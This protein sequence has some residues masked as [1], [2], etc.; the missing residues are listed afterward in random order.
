MPL[1]ANQHC[2][3]KICKFLQGSKQKCA[4]SYL[5]KAQGPDVGDWM[6]NSTGQLGGKKA[7][8]NEV[9]DNQKMCSAPVGCGGQGCYD[10]AKTW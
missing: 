7:W 4:Y 2:A 1:P 8:T 5:P 6:V 9:V 10:N 3:D